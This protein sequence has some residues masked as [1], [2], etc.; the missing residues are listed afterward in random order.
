[1]PRRIAD[2]LSRAAVVSFFGRREELSLLH[3]AIESPELPF[4]IAF[5][6][7]SGGIG[8]SSL[9]HAVLR[10]FSPEIGSIFMDCREI[11]PTPKGLL[12]AVGA[13]LGM[14]EREPDLQAVVS[15]LD[16]TRRRTVLVL[17]AYETFGL[18]DTWL[19]QVFVPALPEAVLTIIAGQQAPNP[20]WLTTPGWAGLFREIHLQELSDSDARSMLQSRGLTD[21]QAGR[22]NRFARGHPLALEL[23]AAALRAQPDL[24]ISG[25]PLK[26]LK[27]LTQAFLAGLSPERLQAVE[28]ASTV[29]RLTEPIL[30]A[31]LDL[32]EV[33]TLFDD[34]R[35]L[36]FVDVTSDGLVF[37]DVVRDTIAASLAHRD[38]ELYH[39]Y[40]RRAWYFF[41][42]ESHRT[43]AQSLWQC[44]ADLLYLIE[45]P[46]VREA[47]FPKGASEYIVEPATTA[48]SKDILE[49]AKSEGS[50]E[51]AELLAEWWERHPETFSVVK[52]QGGKV[53]AF[54]ILFDPTSVDAHLLR[55]D[56]LTAAWLRHLDRNPVAIGECVLFLRRWLD[57]ATGELPSPTQAACWLDIK[58]TYMDLRPSLRRVYT[59]VI[60]L[61]SYGPIV[62]P[63]G[64]AR[65]EQADVELGGK[66]YH[67][68][69]LDFGELS[70]D[71][72]LATR[73]GNEL[74]SGV[75]YKELQKAPAGLV[76]I[77]FTDI[78]GSTALTQRF[79]DVKAQELLR[80]HNSI[81][82]DALKDHGGFEIKH[83]GDGIMASFSSAAQA[84]ES[85]IAMQRACARHNESA[86]EP[87]QMRIGLNA[88]EPIA[89]NQDLF[90]SSVQLAARVCAQAGA[91]QI[92]VSD[93]LR[94]LS[95]GK[96]FMFAYQGYVA[97]RGFEEPLRL[98]ELLWKA[99]SWKVAGLY[100]EA[101]NC[102]SVCPC[103]SGHMP[104][105]G[106]CEGNSAWHITQGQYGDIPL[107]GLNVIMALR[108]DGHMRSTKWKCWFYID[109]RATSEQFN[110][111]KQIFT[112]A[113]RGHLGKIFGPLWEVQKVELAKIDFKIEGAQHQVSI[114]GK[115]KLAFGLLRP[116]AGPVLCR[117]PNS[118][119]VAAIAE[120]YW[121]EDGKMKF[122]YP[123]KSALTTTFEYHSDQ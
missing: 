77:L 122:E 53:S 43:A 37:H 52:D 23:A 119:G 42:R 104:T 46:F 21:D 113:N 115:L 108:C 114:L 59:A 31:V 85:A 84:L 35:D 57:S 45:N 34:L 54:Y 91:G 60:D 13:K 69:L 111:L 33:R 39:T 3:E 83:T 65:I 110:A 101:C 49:I 78:V 51:A 58:R 16:E 30:R 32:T 61:A 106:F 75:A 5:I 8:K 25:P 120:E 14:P 18:M 19:R 100:I 50:A 40:R 97:L 63:L 28:A 71:G 98:N 116:E 76:T 94:Q 29:R 96:G 48:N 80:I 87:L 68:A 44:T 1:M 121:F 2:R 4:V 22:I 66:T 102:E 123:G 62:L 6:Y 24:N 38:R 103:Y 90:G 112:E 17:D 93:V 118:P 9:L 74:G 47:F 81:V 27:Q 105:Y 7:G 88:G 86:K 20:A 89:E 41:S 109:D 92:L 11:E 82:R 99:S 72:W 73:V 15:H 36:P 95:A 55:D 56:P 107:E 10:S 12:A 117:I 67:S 79:G 26:V 70:V 64:F